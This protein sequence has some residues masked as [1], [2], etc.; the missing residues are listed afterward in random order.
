MR[1]RSPR[2]N[3]NETSSF[4]ASGAVVGAFWAP[5]HGSRN[6]RCT[7]RWLLGVERYAERA[8]PEHEL[9]PSRRRVVVDEGLRRGEREVREDDG[10]VVAGAP[11]HRSQAVDG[12]ALASGR[13][14][15][16]AHLTDDL[17]DRAV[18]G[19]LLARRDVDVD[20]PR[21]RVLRHEGADELAL[22]DAH[23]ADDR[24]ACH[25]A[26]RL[27]S[28]RGLE[29]RR[30][31]I[32]EL[33]LAAEERGLRERELAFALVARQRA[34]ERVGAHGVRERGVRQAPQIDGL[35]V[36]P[37]ELALDEA[38][39]A[40]GDQGPLRLGAL[41]EEL[42]ERG[43]RLAQGDLVEAVVAVPHAGGLPAD[44]GDRGRPVRGLV[45]AEL[46]QELVDVRGAST[47]V[48]WGVA[49]FELEA[50]DGGRAEAIPRP[51]EP[52]PEREAVERLLHVVERS[53]RRRRAPV[54]RLAAVHEGQR[55]D[56]DAAH[57]ALPRLLRDRGG[58]S[59]VRLE[60][61]VRG[62]RRQR[63]ACA[64]PRR[65]A[66]DQLADDVFEREGVDEPLLGDERLADRLRH[67][68]RALEAILSARCERAHRDGLDAGGHVLGDRRGRLDAS[69]ADHVEER[70][71]A[72]PG[73]HRL[74]REGLP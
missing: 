65:A 30:A 69:A 50:C 72:E 11:E 68:A 9:P 38:V 21:L 40:A 7:S 46:A 6:P 39:D 58:R 67:R 64:R 19:V 47:R 44:D 16:L 37:D 49:V 33:D 17:A 28:A 57:L 45:A 66:A 26:R 20:G 48:P 56:G 2:L 53:P 22:A 43:G 31:E 32:V 23:L 54:E 51:A 13:G 73:V 3:T 10:Q 5:C 1:A 24:T 29:E 41:R 60:A 27:A 34:D 36:L 4:S 62:E 35:R 70:L 52:M 14:V 8:R 74:H 71:A 25:A 15:E 61:I 59:G 55:E 18:G 63:R 12:L 42:E